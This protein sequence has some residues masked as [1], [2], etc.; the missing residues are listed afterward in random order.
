MS[1]TTDATDIILCAACG[2]EEDE[3]NKLKACTACKMV[4]YCN[5]DCQIA[6]R[7]QHK[8]ACKKRAAAVQEE[9]LFEQPPPNEDCPVCFL[10]LPSFGE[11]T[12]QSCCGKTLCNGCIDAV[13][14]RT[15]I[16]KH[17]LCPFCRT[18]TC[19]SKEEV[20]ERVQKRVGMNDAEAISILASFYA[21][22]ERGAARDINRAVELLKQATELG[23]IE[24]CGQL[25]D[26]Y[27]PHMKRTIV[28]VEKDLNATFHYYEMA[29]KGGHDIARSNLGILQCNFGNI[30]TGMKHFMIAAAQGHDSALQKVKEG[31][32]EGD[33]T[34]DD[35]AKALHAHKDAQDEVHSEQ[36]T[37]SKLSINTRYQSICS[38]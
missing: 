12:Y 16:N 7:R 25:G 13:Y 33:V 8:K 31:Y 28:G 37:K 36:R 26:A 27:N 29:A 11:R 4:K 30:S 22:D 3:D 24:A 15:P 34:K 21:D 32:M 23:S 6:H 10:P 35:F 18:P 5:R 9:A 20:I 19:T 17:P 14:D 38:T 2:K 1:S